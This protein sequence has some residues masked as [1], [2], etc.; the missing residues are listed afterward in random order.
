MALDTTDFNKFM[1]E[2][3][4]I[5]MQQ[6]VRERGYQS[7][8]K[9]QEELQRSGLARRLEGY[10]AQEEMQKRLLEAG[11][12]RDVVKMLLATIFKGTEGYGRPGVEAIERIGQ[13]G[14]GET[15]GVPP[16]VP[17]QYEEVTTGHENMMAALGRRLEE[18][19]YPSREELAVLTRQLGPEKVQEFLEQ[20]EKVKAGRAARQVSREKT[21]LGYAELGL[22]TP[23]AKLTKK[24]LEDKLKFF[25]KKEKVFVDKLETLEE[26]IGL[27]EDDPKA[28]QLK[29]QI[30]EMRQNQLN[31]LDQLLGDL[32]KK[33]CDGIIS[34][35]K[36][37]QI[38]AKGM[39][40]YKEK[41]KK[42]YKL[43]DVEYQYIR[44]NI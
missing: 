9:V 14:L 21:K 37:N 27:T 33:K 30:S 6:K 40:K 35:L 32:D 19:E 7:W 41:F 2:L 26:E 28:E 10:T 25:S 11:Y 15:P 34:K 20:A 38:T 42:E 5:L 44:L 16:Q 3:M 22:K 24:Q 12:S 17:G 31:T 1:S 39:E 29:T 18:G 23:G 4:R 8:G 36:A 43:T 13:L